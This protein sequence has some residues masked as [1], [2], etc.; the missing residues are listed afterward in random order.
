MLLH[1]GVFGASSVERFTVFLVP[2]PVFVGA[3]LTLVH[4]VEN[5]VKI[6]V[7]DGVAILVHGVA[8]KDGVDDVEEH[9][10]EKAEHDVR[11]DERDAADDEC[12][13]RNP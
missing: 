12:V 9:H 8:D 2:V 13:N 11:D 6:G 7:V 3:F 4:L 1:A 10:D 5:F